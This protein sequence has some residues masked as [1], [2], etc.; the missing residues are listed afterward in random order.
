[1]I[2]SVAL[3]LLLVVRSLLKLAVLAR[4]RG[5]APLSG[6]MAPIRYICNEDGTCVTI[7]TV[8]G[9]SNAD[10]YKQTTTYPRSVWYVGLAV[11][12]VERVE[13][14]GVVNDYASDTEHLV[15]EGCRGG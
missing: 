12:R 7:A 6:G 3:V 9:R 15:V 14:N 5:D 4:R 11:D 1:M 8:T 13:E 10:L 2:Q